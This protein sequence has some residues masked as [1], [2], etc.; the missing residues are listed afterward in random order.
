M[1]KVISISTIK[2]I[3]IPHELI[4]LPA[5]NDV[6]LPE[7]IRTL[8]K[9]VEDVERAE[10]EV[11]EA[12]DPYLQMKSFTKE[13]LD[14]WCKLENRHKEEVIDFLK[15][16]QF[17]EAVQTLVKRAD[18]RFY[19]N[20]PTIPEE[21]DLMVQVRKKVIAMSIQ[22]GDAHRATDILMERLRTSADRISRM[23]AYVEAYNR[24]VEPIFK[25]LGLVPEDFD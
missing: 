25:E 2:G 18:R 23:K 17:V 13:M 5:T 16:H 4:D 21:E 12:N 7:D 15:K 19:E 10:R 24:R 20:S 14:D 9:M 8:E 11:R 6:D 22:A 1:K 3:S